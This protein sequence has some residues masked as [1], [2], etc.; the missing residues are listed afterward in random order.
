MSTCSGQVGGRGRRFG[1]VWGLWEGRWDTGERDEWR[2][3]DE[4]RW[5]RR[6]MMSVDGMG[7]RSGEGRGHDEWDGEVG[8]DGV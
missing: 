2:Y 8:E 3:R 5:G 1:G 7:S 4:G 6:C